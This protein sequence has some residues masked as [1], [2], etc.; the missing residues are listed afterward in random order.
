MTTNDGNAE[1]STPT[2]ARARAPA[3]K[4]SSGMPTTGGATTTN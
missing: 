3:S 2:A 1:D 4:H